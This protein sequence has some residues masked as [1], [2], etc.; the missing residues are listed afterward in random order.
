MRKDMIDAVACVGP[1]ESKNTLF[2]Y[3]LITNLHDIDLCR[4]SR[5][6]PVEVSEVIQKIKDSNYRVAF[7]GLPCFIKAL[8][9]FMRIDDCL[10]SKIQFTI[11]LICGHLKSKQYCE[12][13]VRSCGMLPGQVRAV[14]F[15]KK[16]KGLPANQYAFEV[17]NINGIAQSTKMKDVFASSWSNNLFMLGACECCDDVVA[18]T[19]DVSIGDAWLPEFIAD[20]KGTSIVITRNPTLDSLLKRGY[21]D[22][23]IKLKNISESQVIAAQAGSFRQRRDGLR[24]R[25]YLRKKNGQWFSAKRIAPSLKGVPFL[26]RLVQRLRIKLRIIS[27]E[28]FIRKPNQSLNLTYFKLKLIPYVIFMSIIN[29]FRNKL[30]KRNRGSS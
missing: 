9:Y 12:Y 18:E 5:Y 22:N 6:Y 8:H 1:V 21:Q 15:R 16:I 26:F 10:R 30:L 29:R 19:A 25:L 23:A 11:G 7:V 17:T 20:Y 13:L 3:K 24:Y 2:E 14:D 28:S 27:K 4:K